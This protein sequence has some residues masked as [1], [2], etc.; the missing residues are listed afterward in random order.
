M[1]EH[2]QDNAVKTTCKSL[3]DEEDSPLWTLKS[4]TILAFGTELFW[5]TF[6]KM[7]YILFYKLLF[8]LFNSTNKTGGEGI[9]KFA[10]LFGTVKYWNE[11]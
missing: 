7:G 6:L 2:N 8:F 11:R 10:A 9:P 1:Y 5:K 4:H 3:S